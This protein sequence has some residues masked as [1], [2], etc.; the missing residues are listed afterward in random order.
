MTSFV[1]EHVSNEVRIRVL[2]AVGACGASMRLYGDIYYEENV[3]YFV[4]FYDG[5]VYRIRRVA[6]I[7]KDDKC[8]ACLNSVYG[9]GIFRDRDTMKF[10]PVSDKVRDLVL[11]I[12]DSVSDHLR[13]PLASRILTVCETEYYLNPSTKIV[14]EVKGAPNGK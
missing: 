12:N 7:E 1:F 10:V 11:Y 8:K 2:N 14:M 4:H 6:D 13:D 3:G 9:T 5:I